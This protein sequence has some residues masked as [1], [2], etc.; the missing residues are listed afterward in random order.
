MTWI[1]GIARGD[2]G[3]SY[4]S[5][6]SVTTLIG[7]RVGATL[8][9]ALMAMIIGLA[10]AVPA[11][12][13]GAIWPNRYLNAVLS[14]FAAI[15]IA[16]PTFVIGIALIIAIGVELDVLPTQGYVSFQ[17]DPLNSVESTLLPAFTLGIGVAAVTMRILRASLV[18]IGSASF[19]RTARGKGLLR[20]Q[21]VVRHELPNASIPAITQ[22]GIIVAHLVGG[23]VIV[24]YVF[25]RPGLGH[26]PRR[27]GLPARLRGPADARPRDRRRLHRHEPGR[28]RAARLRRPEVARG[29]G[30][31][32]EAIVTVAGD[33]PVLP[34]PESAFRRLMRTPSAAIAA[35]IVLILVVL[36]VGA[37]LVSPY[38][39]NVSD[40]DKLFAPPSW[41]HLFGT[42]ELGRDLFTRL[43]YGGR[44]SLIVAVAAT[45]IAMVV[46]VA[47]GFAAAFREGWIGELLMRIADM[48]MAVPVIFLGLVLVAAFG[49]SL[50]SLIV[51][52]GLLFAPATARLARSTLLVELRS[53]YYVSAVSVGASGTRI[54]ARELFPNA[55]P[56]LIARASLILA[57]AIFVEASLSFVGLGIQPPDTSW[58]TLLQQGYSNL[59]RSYSYPLFPGFVILV[60]VLALNALGDN[61]QKVLDP[62]RS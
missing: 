62:S 61:L 10:I 11:S 56:V 12:V 34:R 51:I 60:A 6:F 47:W 23:A 36:T 27:L 35:V 4:F 5:Q 17:R 33:A 26:A 50:W 1:S 28:R 57:E 13:A 32:S 19:V 22:A 53:E 41:D 48:L 3:N 46:G 16:I 40:F 9:L 54:V 45:V 31:V 7:Q 25:A 15:G 37:P 39:P 38:S 24:E 55:L 58:G 52:L 2:F 21:V 43:L 42:D 59:Y 20:S 49:A 29:G 8:L 14:A 30:L 18:E 44:T